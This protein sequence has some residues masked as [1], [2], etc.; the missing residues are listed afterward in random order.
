MTIRRYLDKI[1]VLGSVFT[2]LCCLGF[3]ALLSILSA[4]GLG[5]LINDAILLPLLVLFLLA[6]IAGLVSG[7]RFHAKPWALILGIPSSLLVLGFLFVHFNQGLVQAG[8][9]GLVLAGLLNV[10]LQRQ[11]ETT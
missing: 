1:G 11:C 10:W 7:M 3:P 2:A 9:V 8:I 4:I 6:T 5:F